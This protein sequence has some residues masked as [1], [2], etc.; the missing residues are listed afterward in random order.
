M[1]N[2]YSVLGVPEGAHI[3]QV[4]AAYRELSRQYREMGDTEAAHKK[5]RDIDEAYDSIVMGTSS[6]SSGGA[7]Y[8]QYTYSEPQRAYANTNLSDIREKVREGRLE[9]AEIL[10][11]GIPEQQRNAEWYYLKGTVQQK[12]GWLEEAAKN[13]EIASDLEPQNSTF[14]AALGNVNNA[15]S[16]GYK[17]DRRAAKRGGDSSGC[18]FC[19]MCSSL[20]CADCCCECMGGDLIPCC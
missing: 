19:D 14:R 17:T 5:M 12:R 2:P 10:L 16:G 18:D 6:S 8:E 1:K 20:L 4:K 9:D 3:E 13:F 7:A 15:R 11:D